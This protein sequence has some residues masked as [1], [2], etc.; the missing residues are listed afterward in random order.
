MR[1]PVSQRLLLAADLSGTIE[2]RAKRQAD[3]RAA[4]DAEISRSAREIETINDRLVRL[5][6]DYADTL[7]TEREYARNKARYEERAAALRRRM[8]DLSQRAALVSDVS[9][10]RWLAAARAFQNPTELT[11]EMLE[12]MVERI[13]VSGPE[14]VDVVWKF[15]DEFALLES[16]AGEEAC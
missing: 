15:R 13:V 7:L 2:K 6:E 12:A 5:Y 10:N 1:R 8:D 11:R 9:D 3:P 14:N 16:C 4:I